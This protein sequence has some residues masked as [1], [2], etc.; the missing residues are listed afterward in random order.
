MQFNDQSEA[1]LELVKSVLCASLY[2][3]SAWRVVEGPMRSSLSMRQPVAYALGMVK[4]AA[5]RFL[6]KRNLSLVKRFPYR[7]ELRQQGLDWP[8]FGYSMIGR[9][10]LD[11]IQ[12]C[13]ERVIADEVPGDLMETGVWRGGATMLMRAVLKRHNV[14]DRVVWCADSF[15]GLPVP[16]ATD[17]AIAQN[18]DFSDREYLA[19]SKEQVAANFERLGL[20][21]AQVKFLKGWFKDTLPTAPIE[22]L[23]ILRL[24]GDL[25]EST[26]DALTHMYPKL[27]PGGFVLIDDYNSWAGCKQ[28]VTEYREKNGIDAKIEIVDAHACYWQVSHEAAQRLS[29]R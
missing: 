14:I 28:A 3:E 20:L 24:D 23:A 22:R 11:N 10:R 29:G 1:Y 2:D 12:R 26:L 4:R 15:E 17:K 13:V 18:V 8:M 21:D 27:S 19:V 25:Y 7:D 6:R 16:N 9:K 5:V